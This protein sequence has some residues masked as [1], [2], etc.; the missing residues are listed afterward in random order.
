MESNKWGDGR[1]YQPNHYTVEI[2]SNN[3]NNITLYFDDQ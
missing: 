3:G 2:Y 1:T